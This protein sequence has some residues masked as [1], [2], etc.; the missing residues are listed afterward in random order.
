MMTGPH[1]A[2]ELVCNYFK[3]DLPRRV[4]AF[5][6]YWN[7]SEEELPD[8]PEDSIVPWAPPSI[9]YGDEPLPCLYNVIARTRN[10]VQIGWTQELDP[11]YRVNYEARSYIWCRADSI[12]EC[13]IMR[14][15]LLTVVR[16]AMLD[17]QCLRANTPE[18]YAMSFDQTTL[19]EEFSDVVPSKN[20][21]W[22]GGVYIGYDMTIDETVSRE[23]I[24]T[25]SE[26][27]VSNYEF[28]E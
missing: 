13:N 17:E 10:M 4:V 21:R 19:R 15:R 16:T 6:N 25:I 27:E 23:A 20:D 1:G 5:R 7:I 9:E 12:A 18:M 28:L 11:V 8:F 14:D 2:K 22:I 3:A 26:I 24:G